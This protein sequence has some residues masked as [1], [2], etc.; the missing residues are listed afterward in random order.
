[1]APIRPALGITAV[2]GREP[3]LLGAVLVLSLAM[4]V[5]EPRAA[6]GDDPPAK[7]KQEAIALFR[8]VVERKTAKSGR[9]YLAHS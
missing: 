9:C 2:S 6:A 5:A 7:A 1:M 3:H 8:N 4:F